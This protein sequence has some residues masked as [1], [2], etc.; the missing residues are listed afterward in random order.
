LK[1]FYLHFQSKICYGKIESTD[2]KNTSYFNSI[3]NNLTTNHVNN[4]SK[5]SELKYI[6][7]LNS[8]NNELKNL[9]E[10]VI[11]NV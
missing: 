2:L 1:W 5:T 7:E 9:I 6:E 10:Q 3:G 8:Q 11:I 4:E